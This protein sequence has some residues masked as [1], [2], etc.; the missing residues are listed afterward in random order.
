MHI[1]D[2]ISKS[3]V[4][5]INVEGSKMPDLEYFKIPA[6]SASKL[7]LISPDEDGS[8][9]KY[10]AGF[11]PTYS[12]SMLLGSAVHSQILSEDEYIV[13]DYEGKPSGKLGYFVEKVYEFR[14]A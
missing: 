14:K 10:L 6:I 8:K 2:F 4:E 12:E 1:N 3:V 13:S 5:V 7:K 9:D 11:Q